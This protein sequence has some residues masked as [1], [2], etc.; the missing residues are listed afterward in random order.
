MQQRDAQAPNPPSSRVHL[1][2]LGA[3]PAAASHRF[4]LLY[5][6]FPLAFDALQ[7]SSAERIA[8]FHRCELLRVQ[9]LQEEIGTL[10]IC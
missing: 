7:W 10:R 5:L 3:R 9:L 2:L 1:H 8:S 6:R 4:P